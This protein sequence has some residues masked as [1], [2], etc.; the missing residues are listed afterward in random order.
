MNNV[1]RLLMK[2]RIKKDI[3]QSLSVSQKKKKGTL[4]TKKEK[5]MKKPKVIEQ[6]L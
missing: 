4:R 6:N 5:G 1:M 2:G 3:S